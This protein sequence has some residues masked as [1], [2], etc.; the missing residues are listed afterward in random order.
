MCTNVR[1]LETPFHRN[2]RNSIHFAHQLTFQLF[3]TSRWTTPHA[4]ITAATDK[5][6]SFREFPLDVEPPTALPFP[7]SSTSTA[8]N[9]KNG[10]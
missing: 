1:T 7:Y 8:A 10:D 5:K 6:S 2:Y 9:S 4:K 3:A